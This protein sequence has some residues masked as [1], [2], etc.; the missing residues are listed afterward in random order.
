M[1]ERSLVILVLHRKRP[2]P[3]IPKNTQIRV[4]L[5]QLRVRV[6]IIHG[7]KVRVIELQELLS[8]RLPTLTA[9]PLL[10]IPSGNVLAISEL[11]RLLPQ[12]R[13][14]LVSPPQSVRA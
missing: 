7:R 10:P 13:S 5:K 6:L 11:R 3:L 2:E 4:Q 12:P 8:P 14:L 1:K 9:M